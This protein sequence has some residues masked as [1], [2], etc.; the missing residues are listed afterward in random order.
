MTSVSQL[1]GVAWAFCPSRSAIRIAL[2][3]A[4][5][6]C[7]SSKPASAYESLTTDLRGVIEEMKA[8]AES[9][10]GGFQTNGPSA[11][12]AVRVTGLESRESGVAEWF[13]AILTKQLADKAI[14]VRNGA[15]HQVRVEL[16]EVIDSK[17]RRL[18]VMLTAALID[19]NE[20][21]LFRT[22]RGLLTETAVAAVTGLS[23]ALPYRGYDARGAKMLDAA[24]NPKVDIKNDVV[25]APGSALYGIELLDDTASANARRPMINKSQRA[26]FALSFAQKTARAR[27]S[28]DSPDGAV[29]LVIGGGVLD[30]TVQPTVI[31]LPPES[32]VVYPVTLPA[33]GRKLKSAD[34]HQRLSVRFCFAG[35]FNFATR[36]IPDEI[37]NSWRGPDIWRITALEASKYNTLE[38]PQ[39]K[40]NEERS[41][42]PFRTCITIDLQSV[43]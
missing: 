10:K 38:L 39:W 37:P 13:E 9:L 27:I 35:E 1:I 25:R 20:K 42:G 18:G 32:S 7:G 31:Y 6:L 15:P 41:G 14:A 24:D 4:A 26:E 40:P 19:A 36:R 16:K 11:I 17:S 21:V 28:N 22:S 33:S 23:V 5:I 34:E 8:L 3:A 12:G 2:V 30:R 29:V 43:P